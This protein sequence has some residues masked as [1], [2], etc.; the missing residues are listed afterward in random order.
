MKLFHA[1]WAYWNPILLVFIPYTSFTALIIISGCIIVFHFVWMMWNAS[2]SHFNNL[3]LFQKC[4]EITTILKNTSYKNALGFLT[5]TSRLGW[6]P[7]FSLDGDLDGDGVVVDMMMGAKVVWELSWWG[8][9][10]DTEARLMGGTW[11]VTGA[12][13]ID[14]LAM[15]LPS[16]VKKMVTI[17]SRMLVSLNHWVKYIEVPATNRTHQQ[18]SE[19][20]STYPVV[21]KEQIKY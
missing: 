13:Q 11:W 14:T 6:W 20:M 10:D 9:S 17:P 21:H 12:L 3:L 18:S 19:M 15:G 7:S 8:K 1:L 5:S 4:W 2:C 16:R